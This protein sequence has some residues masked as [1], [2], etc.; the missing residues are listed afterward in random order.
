VVGAH[1]LG[2]S[3]AGALI[4]VLTTRYAAHL[5][6]KAGIDLGASRHGLSASAE[7]PPWPCRLLGRASI[8]RDRAGSR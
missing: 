8:G 7:A 4:A 6:S 2:D 5:F 1:Y 3:L